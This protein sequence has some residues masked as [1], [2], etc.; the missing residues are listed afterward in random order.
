VF[1]LIK[2][3]TSKKNIFLLFD[4]LPPNL[5]KSFPVEAP[6]PKSRSFKKQ[7]TEYATQ[8]RQG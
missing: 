2:K 4:E 7:K 5:K 8:A 1:L 3:N 6:P